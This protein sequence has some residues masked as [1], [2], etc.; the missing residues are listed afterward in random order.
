M[1]TEGEGRRPGLD[2]KGL[3]EQGLWAGEEALSYPSA[4]GWSRSAGLVLF[5]AR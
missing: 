3:D 5:L 1:Y 2:A 4:S